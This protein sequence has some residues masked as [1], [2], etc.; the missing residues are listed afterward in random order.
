M[1]IVRFVLFLVSVISVTSDLALLL[2][3]FF[4]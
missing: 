1:R 4:S 2:F 3:D